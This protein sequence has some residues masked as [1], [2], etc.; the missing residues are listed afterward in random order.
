MT[1]HDLHSCPVPMTP[2]DL[3]TPIPP[4]PCHPVQQGALCGSARRQGALP[5]VT[6]ASAD[7]PSVQAPPREFRFRVRPAASGAGGERLGGDRGQSP[8][9]LRSLF[10]F[11]RR[12]PPV[13]PP[14][15]Q[16]P[17]PLWQR[18]LVAGGAAG[19]AAGAWLW[20]R[21]RREQERQRRRREALRGLALTHAD[22]RLRDQTG[23]PRAKSDFRGQWVL[24]YFGF[25]HC[26]DVCPAALERMGRAAAALERDPALPPLQPLFV[27]VDP[28]RDDEA[29]LRRYLRDFHPRLLGLTGSAE[30]VRAAA[31]AFRVYASAGPR[32]ADGDYIVDHSVLIY[33]LGPDGLLLDCYGS[34]KSAEELERSVREHMRTYQPLE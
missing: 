3:V 18:A 27:T 33:L 26:P 24:L 22:F 6:P 16:A 4:P 10:S 8:A 7:A 20:L 12:R 2:D 15:R 25:T 19:A 17:L 11:L 13:P 29:A 31:A 9:M 1:L 14:R 23:A 21:Q 30:D 32:D 5:R 28:E 34:G